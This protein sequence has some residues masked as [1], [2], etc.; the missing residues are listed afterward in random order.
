MNDIAGSGYLT[1]T[2][3]KKT[4][5]KKIKTSQFYYRDILNPIHLNGAP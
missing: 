4:K 3:S 1:L 5:N 2:N